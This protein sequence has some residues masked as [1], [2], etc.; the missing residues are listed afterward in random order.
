LT[1]FSRSS[2]LMSD[3]STRW[4]AEWRNASGVLVGWTWVEAM[5]AGSARNL[6]LHT[7]THATSV[8]A[9]AVTLAVKRSGTPMRYEVR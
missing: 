1:R 9:G 8:E 2:K 4:R 5:D 6:A 3:D 7:S